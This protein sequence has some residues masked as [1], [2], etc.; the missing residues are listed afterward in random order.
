MLYF[1]II[2]D[3]DK[4]DLEYSEGCTL[5]YVLVMETDST[6]D[7]KENQTERS[8]GLETSVFEKMCGNFEKNITK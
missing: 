6:P 8:I 5:D 2:L 1:R 4:F 7:M 3:W